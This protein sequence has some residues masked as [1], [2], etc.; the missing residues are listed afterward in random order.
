MNP[1]FHDNERFDCCLICVD[2]TKLVFAQL[3]CILGFSYRGKEYLLT[4]IIPY[5]LPL[6]EANPSLTRVKNKRDKDLRFIQVRSRPTKN[7]EVVFSGSIVRG[8]LLAQDYSC[9]SGDDHLVVDVVDPDM[10]LRMKRDRC[11]LATNVAL[12]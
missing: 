3:V 9:S 6:V 2:D 11:Q 12:S 1:S 8:A 10:W 5:D 4:V 7:F